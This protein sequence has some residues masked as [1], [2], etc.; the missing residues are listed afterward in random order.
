MGSSEST[1]ALAQCVVP[2]ARAS[3]CQ[4]PSL[5]Q[6]FLFDIAFNLD[7]AFTWQPSNSAHPQFCRCKAASLKGSVL[8]A[9]MYLD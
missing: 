8:V 2:W 5:K 4:P 3:E 7:N 1:T 6:A 9:S